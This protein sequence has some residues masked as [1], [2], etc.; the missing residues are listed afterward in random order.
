[1]VWGLSLKGVYQG[2]WMV[3]IG[4]VVGATLLALL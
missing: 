3:N 1:M 2:G 4:T